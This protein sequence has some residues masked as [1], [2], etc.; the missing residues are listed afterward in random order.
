LARRQQPETAGTNEAIPIATVRGIAMK[1]GVIGEGTF[2]IIP[3]TILTSE[4]PDE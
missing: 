3:V 4:N 2:V 1:K